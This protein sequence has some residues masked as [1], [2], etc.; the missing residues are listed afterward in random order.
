MKTVFARFRA[1]IGMGLSA[2]LLACQSQQALPSQ[3]AD[4]SDPIDENWATLGGWRECWLTESEA[5]RSYE[6]CMSGC[7]DS[8]VYDPTFNCAGA[9]K[10][11]WCLAC[12]AKSSECS[13]HKY[14]F[15]GGIYSTE[16]KTSCDAAVARDQ[17]C[18]TPVVT[19]NCDTVAVVES[20]DMAARY[21]CVAKLPCG[22][23][24]DACLP[25]ETGS[26]WAAMICDTVASVCDGY[27]CS[28]KGRTLLESVEPWLRT[29]ATR[30]ATTCLGESSCRD[31]RECLLA[32]QRTVFKD[33]PYVIL[34][35]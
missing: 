6:L 9:C 26:S 16:L 11:N 28:D 21:E 20:S 18:A 19:P 35:D 15:D 32:W 2:V 12:D 14:H 30:A 10:D 5:R 8:I 23:G 29:D 13:L 17:R 3:N 7:Y 27:Y 34:F 22:G 1:W 25:Q 31:I 33:A 4:G 24:P